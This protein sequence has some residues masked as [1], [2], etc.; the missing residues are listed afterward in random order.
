MKADRR[1][2]GLLAEFDE[3]HA[4]LEAARRAREAG[5]TRMEAYTPFP[6][7]GLAAALGFGHTRLPFIVLIG[8][9]VGAVGGFFMQWYASVVSYPINIAGRPLNSWPAFIVI[10]FELTILCAGLAAVLGMLA[11]NG[12]PQPYHPLFNIPRFELASRSA[13]FLSLQR[14]DPRFDLVE[15]RRFLEGLNPK[16]IYEVPVLAE[17]VAKST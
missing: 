13:F 17:P 5:Y 6:V 1:I 2:Y 15:T 3:P 9:I 7:H 12:L 14:R 8:G 11:L 4:L 10:T 16:A